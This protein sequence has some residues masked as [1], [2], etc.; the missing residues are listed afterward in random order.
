[1]IL[2]ADIKARDLSIELFEAA[3]I[4]ELQDELQTWLSTRTEEVII[5]LEFSADVATSADDA[6]YRASVIYTE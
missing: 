5:G 6:S 1:M 3:T 4:M 2:P